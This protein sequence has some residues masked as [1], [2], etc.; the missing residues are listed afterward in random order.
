MSGGGGW[1]ESKLSDQLWLSFSLAFAKPNN[2]KLKIKNTAKR[3]KKPLVFGTADMTS[4][5]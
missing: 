5:Y 3:N 1:L 4:P 2:R